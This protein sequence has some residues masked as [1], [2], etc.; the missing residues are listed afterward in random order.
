MTNGAMAGEGAWT[1]EAA[2]KVAVCESGGWGMGTGGNYVGDMGIT[3]ANWQNYGGGSDTSPA[4]QIA[5]ASRIQSYPPDQNGCQ[6]GG[7]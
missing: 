3:Q 6:P 7:W 4:A 5:V 1:Y 2:T